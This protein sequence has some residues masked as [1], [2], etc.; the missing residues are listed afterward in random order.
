M[1][2]IKVLDAFCIPAEKYERLKDFGEVIIVQSKPK[3]EEEIINSCKGADIL[4]LS[5][6]ELTNGVLSKLKNIKLIC[7]TASGFDN[8]DIKAAKQLGIPVCNIPGYGST[9]VAE[10]VFALLFAMVRKIV[11]ANNHIKEKRRKK[12]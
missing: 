1:P 4:I 11:P 5:K 6:T 8:V 3:G 10:H 2:T 12:T 7:L 9:A